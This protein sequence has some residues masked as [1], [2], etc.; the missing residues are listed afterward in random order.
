MGMMLGSSMVFDVA[1][2][3]TGGVASPALLDAQQQAFQQMM[4]KP[5]D[6]GAAFAYGRASLAAEDYEG[7]IVAY[8]RLLLIAPDANPL[9]L[10]L[11]GFYTR[12]NAP[13]L[14]RSY[15]AEYL[16]APNLSAADR[17]RAEQML[18]GLDKETNQTKLSGSVTIGFRQ[19]SNANA[20]AS[21]VLSGGAPIQ[22]SPE[23]RKRADGNVFG[24]LALQHVYDLE[25]QDQTV[26]VSDFSAYYSRQLR[27]HTLSLVSLEFRTGPRFIDA[28]G[29]T[30]LTLRPHVLTGLVG[31]GHR[32]YTTQGG[33]GLDVGYRFTDSIDV[34]A[35]GDVQ[36]R[37]FHT[38]I[39]RPTVNEQTGTQYALAIKPRWSIDATNSVGLEAGLRH[40]D[41]RRNWWDLSE[42]LAGANYTV[43]FTDPIGLTEEQWSVTLSGARVWGDYRLPDPSVAP[44]LK[45]RDREWRGSLTA[46]APLAPGWSAYAQ[47]LA[48][49]VNS[50]IENFRY[51][52][53]SAV[54]GLT[55]S[56]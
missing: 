18:A 29:V 37:D 10:E 27:L 14:A 26:I 49:K 5:L 36:H 41:A 56:F 24:V 44:T 4:T 17:A 16:A 19:Q 53:Y 30:G 21:T 33:G 23:G 3:Q 35:T 28:F 46:V 22:S 52:N 20:G 50:N 55:R 45:R 12:L 13:K 6:A 32:L 38:S 54:F 40:I 43:R 31:L 39:L 2:A 25:A 48:S 15:V 34:T 9:R 51:D 11:A 8:E 42:W 1:L 47:G 7:A